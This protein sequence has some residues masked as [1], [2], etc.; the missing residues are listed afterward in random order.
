MVMSILRLDMRSPG[1][2][3]ASTGELYAAALEMASFAEEKGFATVTLSEHHGTE[4]GYL[5]APLTLAASILGRT[6]RIRVSIGALLTPLYDPLKLAEDLVV[7]DHV[8]PGR[9]NVVAG[10]GYREEEYAM[11]GR[12]WKERGRLLDEALET[13]QKAFTGEPFEYRGRTVRVTPRPATPGGP[14][15][16]VGGQSKRAARRAARF[17]LPFSPASNDAEML[18][19]YQSECE[20]LGVERP[21]VLPPGEATTVFVSEDPERSWQELGPHLLH[22]A[23]TYASWQPASQRSA[24]HSHAQSID[25]L[26]REGLYRI[27]TPDECVAHAQGQGARARLIHFPLCGGAPPSLGW[28][29]LELY[30]ERVLP[31]LS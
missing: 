31:R 30:A 6:R 29:S 2:S 26:R 12:D 3:A 27:L 14:S 17:G 28:R 22:D 19:L 9:L 23:M 7:L 8:A 1:F 24:V 20:R 5:P 15:I 16:M 13:L 4:D 11:F 18:A 25:D 10:I 21:F